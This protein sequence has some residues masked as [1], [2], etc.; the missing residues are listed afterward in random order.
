ML[1]ALTSAPLTSLVRSLLLLPCG[2][3]GTSD[4]IMNGSKG[5]KRLRCGPDGLLSP[6]VAS[7]LREQH[8][9]APPLRDTLS[10]LGPLS[11]LTRGGAVDTPRKRPPLTARPLLVCGGVGP[12][13]VALEIGSRCSSVAPAVHGGLEA[14]SVIP[15]LHER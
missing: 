3:G 9:T 5:P 4:N 11:V 13:A 8:G 6:A 1:T 12:G 15:S 7:F 2:G 14:A 10:P